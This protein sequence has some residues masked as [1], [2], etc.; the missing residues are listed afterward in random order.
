MIVS[1]LVVGILVALVALPAFSQTSAPPPPPAPRLEWKDKLYFG[2]GVGASFGD[3]DY[4]ELAPLVGYQLHPRVSVGLGLL[5][6][7][8]SDD[9]FAVEQNTSD[10]GGS[11]YGRF[12]VYQQIFAQVEYEYLDYEYATSTGGTF[13]DSDSSVLAGAGFF[14]PMGGH[15]GLYASALY[16]FSYD[17]NDLASAYDSPWVYRVGVTFGF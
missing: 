10:Y 11:L 13:R 5:Y 1:R 2:G 4:V 15:A 16:N 14:Q 17:E 12:T 6:R 3:V 9:R 8:K 7:W